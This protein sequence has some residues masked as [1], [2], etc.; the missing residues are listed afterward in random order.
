MSTVHTF[1]KNVYNTYEIFSHFFVVSSEKAL[2]T[3][4]NAV[5]HLSI[6]F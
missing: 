3:E 6:S 4:R 5:Y 1:F 2:E